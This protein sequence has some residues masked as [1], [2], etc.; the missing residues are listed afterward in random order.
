MSADLRPLLEQIA[1]LSHLAIL[2]SKSLPAS[3]A[4]LATTS[5]AGKMIPCHH[6]LEQGAPKPELARLQAEVSHPLPSALLALLAASNG[7]ELF[8]LTYD[9]GPLSKYFIAR[10]Q[11]LS[12]D[13]IVSTSRRLLD[14]YTAYVVEDL[15]SAEAKALDLDYVPFCNVGDGDFLA[16]KMEGSDAG[17]VFLLDHDYGYFPYRLVSDRPYEVIDRNLVEWLQRLLQTNGRDGTGSRYYPL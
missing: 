4:A 17:A 1:Q 16:V 15:A 11:L 8:C 13:G 6:L 2:A 12:V 14:T 10:Y 5:A 3:F 9:V 7:A